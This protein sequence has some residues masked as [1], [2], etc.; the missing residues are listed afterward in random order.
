LTMRLGI[1]RTR[2]DCPGAP[3]GVTSALGFAG[4][5]SG[6]GPLLRID[7]NVITAVR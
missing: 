5:A 6:R 3:S 1:R 7:L 4:Y 2:Q